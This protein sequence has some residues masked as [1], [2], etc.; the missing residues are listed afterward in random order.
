MF[1]LRGVSS[2]RLSIKALSIWIVIALIA[3]NFAL[4]RTVLIVNADDNQ[5]SELA[6]NLYRKV[7]S[8]ISEHLEKAGFQTREDETK[9]VEQADFF[10]RETDVALLERVRT[11]QKGQVDYI[12][13]VQILANTVLL[14]EGTRIE[15]E[16][17]GRMLRVSNGDV[18]ARFNLAVPSHLNA[19]PSCNLKCIVQLLED[20]TSQLANSLGQV[21]A[22]RLQ[23]SP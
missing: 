5:Q 10:V 4:A 20:N 7:V 17:L 14:E 21:L 2:K 11:E 8:R 6:S 23:G 1:V 18:L 22:K 16:I 15:V 19:P 9:P 12:A 13:L 3:P